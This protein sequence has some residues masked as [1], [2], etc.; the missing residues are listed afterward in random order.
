MTEQERETMPKYIVYV[1]RTID[2]QV[3]VE[4]D[5]AEKACAEAERAPDHEF[6]WEM[7][8]PPE[9]LEAVKIK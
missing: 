1:R 3:T 4:A 7:T 6:A 5:S 8:E 2:G 9:A